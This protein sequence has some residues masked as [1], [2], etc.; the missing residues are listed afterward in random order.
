M[1]ITTL[2]LSWVD[3]CEGLKVRMLLDDATS[4]GS[5]DAQENAPTEKLPQAISDLVKF[6]EVVNGIISGYFTP[7]QVYQD[8]ALFSDIRKGTFTIGQTEI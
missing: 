5:S 6:S 3:V 4:Q 7:K 2:A 8:R 1:A